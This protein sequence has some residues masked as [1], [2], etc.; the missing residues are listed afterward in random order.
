MTIAFNPNAYTKLRKLEHLF[1]AFCLLQPIYWVR[2]RL[3]V[4]GRENVPKGRPLLI[5]GNHLSVFDPPLLCIATGL[6]MGY[7]AKSELFKNKFFGQLILYFGSIEINRNKPSK[8]TIKAVKKVIES[9]WNIGMFIE[10]TRS[11]TE[12]MLG[13]PHL[14]TAYFARANNLPILPVGLIGTNKNWQPATARIGKLIEPDSDLEKTT[15]QVMESLADLTGYKIDR[16][17]AET[18]E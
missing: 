7:L 16:H 11:K 4:Y 18:I 9:G 14:G 2:N 13:R 3:K 8:S 5:V 17:L 12:G 6:P 10:G 15:W 1:V